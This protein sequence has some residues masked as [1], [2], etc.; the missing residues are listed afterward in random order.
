M[1]IGEKKVVSIEYT[2]KDDKGEVLDTSDGREP[3]TYM[4]GVGN[5][6]PGLEN[7]LEGKS[8]GDAVEVTLTPEEGYGR[9]DDKLV[10]NIPLRKLHEP[11]PKV[12]GRYRAKLDDGM[13]VVLVTAVKGD[14]AT[15]DANHPLSDKTLHF[16]VKVV[17]V[18]EAT[19]DEL[20][21]GHVHGEG[22]H[23]H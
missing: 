15:V 4:Q 6:V 10:R 17:K 5:L 23:H 16:T 1:Q 20:T 19:S 2:L 12:G 11:N 13:A 18:R 7:A 8:A 21:H 22:G 3:L 9:R 14:Y